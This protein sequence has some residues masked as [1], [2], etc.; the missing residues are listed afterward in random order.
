M[1]YAVLEFSYV[2]PVKRPKTKDYSTR[3]LKHMLDIARACGG[4]YY[5]AGGDGG[6]GFSFDELKE[7]MNK[8]EHLPNKKEGEK[9]RR[10]KQKQKKERNRP[11]GRR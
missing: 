4:N 6:P 1:S 10:E 7:E 2:K 5:F 11:R 3:D 9:I 8:R